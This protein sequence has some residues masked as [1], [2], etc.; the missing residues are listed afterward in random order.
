MKNYNL[1]EFTN[2]VHYYH[3]NKHNGH[4]L[5]TL[6]ITSIYKSKGFEFSEITILPSMRDLAI[7]VAEYFI[8][9]QQTIKKGSKFNYIKEFASQVHTK[10][11]FYDEN[12]AKWIYELNLYYVAITRARDTLEDLSKNVSYVSEECINK[13]IFNVIKK[14]KKNK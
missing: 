14:F 12:I 9:T 13:E 7:M 3:D 2:L 1:E 6:T 11:Q 4:Q 5:P 8:K 10:E